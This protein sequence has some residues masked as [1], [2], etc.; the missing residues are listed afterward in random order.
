[1][2]FQNENFNI[3]SFFKSTKE[4]LNVLQKLF[5]LKAGYSLQ[6]TKMLL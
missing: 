4:V 6:N 3:G 1:M 5:K 2:Q